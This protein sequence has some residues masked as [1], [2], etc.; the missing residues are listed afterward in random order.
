M[1]YLGIDYG[2]KRIGL[3]L[4][5]GKTRVATPFMVLENRGM[6]KVLQELVEIFE[7]EEIKQIVVGVPYSLKERSDKVG[8]QEQTVLD[9]VTR[10]GMAT[11]I[12]IAR[13]DERFTTAEIDKLMAGEKY[14]KEKRDAVSAMLI[15][16]SY[17]DKL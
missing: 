13:Q 2:E 14:P 15:L 16:Q 11:T 17:L 10:L 8:V 5:D 6:D 12:P 9:F 3:A 4:G 1:K 7:D